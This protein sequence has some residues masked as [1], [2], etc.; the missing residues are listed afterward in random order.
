MFGSE[1]A[2]LLTWSLLKII[3]LH[4]ELD[5]FHTRDDE[6]ILYSWGL[7]SSSMTAFLSHCYP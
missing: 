7:E 2:Y 5:L 4:K 6:A 3:R 1:K